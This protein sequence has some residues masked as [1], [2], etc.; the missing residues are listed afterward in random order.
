MSDQGLNSSY[1]SQTSLDYHDMENLKRH[2]TIANNHEVLVTHSS[3]TW[4]IK[5]NFEEKSLLAPIARLFESYMPELEDDPTWE[6]TDFTSRL[7]VAAAFLD[8]TSTSTDIPKKLHEKVLESF[9]NDILGGNDIHEATHTLN[10]Q[11]TFFIVRSFLR[12]LEL[13]G[14]PYPTPESALFMQS[15]LH[16]GNIHAIF[17]GQGTNSLTCLDELRHVYLV[18]E[19]MVRHLIQ[20]ATSIFDHLTSL[21]ETY[22]FYDL[23]GGLDIGRLL[24][25]PYA[26]L[27]VAHIASAPISVPIIGLIGL[28]H[29]CITCQ[30]LGF[31]PGDMQNHLSSVIGHSQGT[32]V[33]DVVARSGSWEE[34]YADSERAL[35]TLFW[36]GFK[37]HKANNFYPLSHDDIQKSMEC[38]DGYPSPMMS[39]AGVDK[40]TVER[41]LSKV[42]SCLPVKDSVSIALIN[43]R[44]NLVVAGPPKTLQAVSRQ[45]QRIQMPPGLDQSRVIFH[46]R[47]PTVDH[48]F[49]PISAPFH[50]LHLENATTEILSALQGKN[51][52]ISDLKIPFYHSRT[53]E[54]IREMELSDMTELLVRM[55]TTEMVDWPKAVSHMDHSHVLDFGPGNIGVLVQKLRIGTGTRVIMASKFNSKSSKIGSKKEMFSSEFPPK[56]QDWLGMYRPHLKI[57]KTGRK[58]LATRMTECMGVPPIMVGGMTPTTVP[59]DFVASVMQ[60]GYHVELAAGGYHSVKDLETSI[61]HIARNIPSRGITINLI[62]ANPRA[63]RW[64]IPLIRQLIQQGLPIDGLTIGAGI[65]SLEIAR[66]YIE[67]MNLRHISF[68]PGSLEAISEVLLIARAFPDFTIGLQWTGGRGGGHHSFEDFH[69]PLLKTYNS[70]R[71]CPN[72]VLIVGSGFGDGHEMFPYLSGC[73]S[74][75][76]GYP[77]MPIDGILLGSRMMVAKEAH[78]SEAAKRLIAETP[79]VSDAEW[80]NSYDRPTGGILTVNSEMG[81]PIHKLATRAVILWHELDKKIFSIKDTS[82]RV[83]EIR[84]NRSWIINRLN[85]DFHKPWFG[86]NM[87]GEMVDVEDMTYF[88]VVSRLISLMYV[89]HQAKWIHSSY[90]TLVLDFICRVEERLPQ[91]RTLD[92]ELG[93]DPER[94]L[95]EFSRSYPSAESELLHPDDVS[96]FFGLCRRRGQKPVNFIPVLDENFEQWF[97]KDSLWQA[98]NLDSVIDQDVQRVCVIHGPVAARHSRIIDEPCQKILDSIHNSLIDLFSDQSHCSKNQVHRTRI[99]TSDFMIDLLPPPPKGILVQEFGQQ[100]SLTVSASKGEPDT[101]V[102]YDYLRGLTQGWVQASLTDLVIMHGSQRQS[103][104]IR[105]AINPQHGY[106]ITFNYDADRKVEVVSLYRNTEAFHAQKLLLRISRYNE[107]HICLRLYEESPRTGRVLSLQL[108]FRYIPEGYPCRITEDLSGRD[109][110]IKNFYSELWLGTSITSTLSKAGVHREFSTRMIKIERSQ[111]KSFMEVIAKSSLDNFS[112]DF[113][114]NIVPLD[115]CIVLAWDAIV[116]PLLIFGISGDL[117]QLLHRSNNFSYCPDEEP[118]RIGDTV[119]TISR[120]GSITNRKNGKLVEVLGEI[121]RSDKPVVML[122]SNFFIGGSFDDSEKT[123]ICINEP[124]MEILV[125]S[126]KEAALLLSRSWLDLTPS[127]AKL[128]GARLVFKL[129]TRATFDH[130]GSYDSLQ[131]SGHVCYQYKGESKENVGKVYFETGRCLGNPVIDFLKRHGTLCKEP[132]PLQNPGW[133]TNSSMKLKIPDHSKHYAIVSNDCNPIHTSPSFA[134]YTGLSGTVTH[135]MFTSASIRKV[136]EMVFAESDPSRFRRWDVN[137]EGIVQPGDVLNIVSRHVSMVDGR[138]IIEA[139]AYNVSSGD[140]VF[141]AE[142]EV[143]QAPTAYIFT[144]QGSQERSMGM[145]LYHSSLA[146]RNAWD[147]G[148]KHLMD[149]YGTMLKRRQKKQLCANRLF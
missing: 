27:N 31:S 39:I 60:A 106:S 97:K 118:L 63:M 109:E 47:R 107:E 24:E 135:G 86:L 69:E 82:K 102:F 48:H 149:L 70:I 91:V 49:L 43:G 93:C 57:D 89:K 29:Y 51:L 15:N 14:L 123:F 125:D 126:E 35:E 83:E 45:L 141:E 136:V 11:S 145:S 101:R 58:T 77:D 16:G 105:A 87:S 20:I 75:S 116:Q 92:L 30:V 13:L 98:E 96:F 26:Q 115:Y 3:Q 133:K 110:K 112:H 134:C 22:L 64:Q 104:P 68:K 41:I 62:Y 85:R 61:Y 52:P 4:I 103:N 38:Q 73:W 65:P 119:Q 139:I 80:H 113:P 2:N 84:K 81:Q 122:K 42:N 108:L 53:G 34:F 37:S 7:V 46:K 129:I 36:I 17:G 9:K 90:Q 121:R 25:R 124:E 138:M 143:D 33:A 21:P 74:R 55:V 117:T 142:A 67:T 54:D 8:H 50:T 18:Y 40:A 1:T 94:L 137:F 99:N 147:R 32:I 71:E 12:S 5:V 140:K 144:G 10:N 6:G 120:I 130:Q 59:W 28:C 131:V 44:D 79:G 100:T 19:P 132:K 56:A 148:D 95:A 88:E 23:H 66:E 128:I 72:I 114:G 146:A 78:T 111:V 76:Y 127:P